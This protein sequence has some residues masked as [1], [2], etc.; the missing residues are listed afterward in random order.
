MKTSILL[1]SVAAILLLTPLPLRTYFPLAVSNAKAPGATD[2][3]TT[4]ATFSATA[5]NTSTATPTQTASATPSA[6]PTATRTSTATPTQTATA[7]PSATPT[8]TFTTSPTVTPSPTSTLT[9]SPTTP[10]T[11]DGDNLVC[12]WVGGAQICAWVSEGAPVRNSLLTVYGRLYIGG[13]PQPDKAMV[14]TWYYRTTTPTCTG[15]TS[16]SGL[17]SC[18]RNIGRATA[19]YQVDILVDVDGYRATTWFIPQ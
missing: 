7:T 12:N 2:T 17:A 8:A 4:T 11:Q 13:I 18:E 10:P 5:T 9:P 6:T 15:T 1:L 19:G 14:A 16:S 3:V